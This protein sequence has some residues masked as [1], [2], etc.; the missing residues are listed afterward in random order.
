MITRITLTKYRGFEHFE[1]GL[2][3]HAFLVGPNSAG[4]STLIEALA[5]AERCVR[6]ARRRKPT[7]GFV[8]HSRGCRGFPIPAPATQDTDDPVR[9]DFGTDEAR[10]DVEW[11][12]GATLHMIWPEEEEEEEDGRPQGRFWLEPPP[13]RAPSPPAIAELCPSLF[14]VPV[15]TPLDHFEELKNT[16]YIKDK[17]GTRLASRHFRNHLRLLYS[18]GGFDDFL[19]FAQPWLPEITVQ[20]VT[21]NPSS[22]R[23]AVFYLERRSRIPKELAW[24]GDGLQI[25]LQ[26][27]WHLYRAQGAATVIL[28][29]PEV[30]LHPDLQRRLV[31]LL[32]DLGPQVIIASHS[33]EVVT[34][35]LPASV[36]WVDRTTRRA[37]RTGAKAVPTSLTDSLGSNY[38]LALVRSLRSRVVVAAEGSDTRALRAFARTAG[39][40]ALATESDLTLVPMRSFSS[41]A[42]PEPLKWIARD[43]L[44]PSALLA[45]LLSGD[46][47][48][49]AFN[50]ALAKDLQS[51]GIHAHVWPYRELTNVF[52]TA[53]VL[54]RAAGTD[55][56]AMRDRLLEAIEHARGEAQ[57][58]WSA[59]QQR[60]SCSGRDAEEFEGLWQ[61]PGGAAALASAPL[62]LGRINEWLAADGYR[63]LTAESAAR[64][65]KLDNLPV[66]VIAALLAVD[67]L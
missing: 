29:E 13:G 34:E 16:D 18:G 28:D 21:F 19:A 8:D 58:H 48:P 62:V 20:D 1:A 12:S 55:E 24:A 17:A 61:Q 4:K 53:P 37:R 31:R 9:F 60:F 10:V 7:M 54:A 11:A 2:A 49:R 5:L 38:N 26:L 65:A 46:S 36:L 42:S 41:W 45:V 22:D 51:D 14:A 50:T 25:W 63:E 6:L 52:L 59:Q 32:E 47:R 39:A 3:P 23:M 44:G 35:A 27:L 15:I 67:E 33:S 43:V 40:T 57:R 30:Y 66:D 64:S 56:Y